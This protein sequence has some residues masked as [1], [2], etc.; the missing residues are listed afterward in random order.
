MALFQT[1]VLKKHLNA[2]D[3]DKVNDAWQR[4]TSYFHDPAI[5]ES[6]RSL[7]EEQYQAIF[8][9]E[10][11]V[12]ILGYTLPPKENHNLITEHK[13]VKD[14]KKADGAILKDG[15]AIA[16]IEL[17]GTNTT[18]LD[19]IEGQAF[20]YKNNQPNALYVITSNFD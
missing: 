17:K 16:V 11:F 5:Q 15:K 1:S 19:K 13:N 14:S 3:Q 2:L 8:L 9:N 10:L 7:N 4:F 18:D 12:K 6:I 20:G